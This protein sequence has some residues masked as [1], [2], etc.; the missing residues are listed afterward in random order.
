M[1]MSLMWA[2]IEPLVSS[3]VGALPE[4]PEPVELLIPWP[5][6]VPFWPFGTGIALVLLVGS[7]TLA[8]RLLRWVYGL[9][10]VLQ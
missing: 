8:L 4:A 3:I 6:A 7:A 9:I 10:P 2:V 1:L 5:A